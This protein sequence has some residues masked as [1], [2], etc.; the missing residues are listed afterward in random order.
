MQSLDLAI[1][2]NR[3][4]CLQHVGMASDTTFPVY[5]P[6]LAGPNHDEAR[7]TALGN[8]KAGVRA[9]HHC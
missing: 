3:G 8:D 2:V 4:F 7:N 1:L 5:P 9:A 6:E